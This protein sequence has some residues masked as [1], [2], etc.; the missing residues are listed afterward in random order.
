MWHLGL[1]KVFD[2]DFSAPRFYSFPVLC[3]INL[4]ESTISCLPAWT[5]H[6]LV[7]RRLTDDRWSLWL[8]RADRGE[9]WMEFFYPSVAN[10]VLPLLSSLLVLNQI[11]CL[12]SEDISGKRYLGVRGCT[13]LLT[14][15]F[16]SHQIVF[17]W[18]KLKLLW[19]IFAHYLKVSFWGRCYVRLG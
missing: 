4:S 10:Y 3:L 18:G 6:C 8:V 19:I 16:L 9:G 13:V 15:D 5:P 2:F 7:F 17:M 1:P 12:C 11:C 14:K